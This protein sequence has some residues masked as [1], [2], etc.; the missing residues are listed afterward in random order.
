MR[1]RRF[2]AN[3]ASDCLHFAKFRPQ[4]SEFCGATYT[5]ICEMFSTL[6]STSCLVTDFENRVQIVPQT[7]TKLSKNAVINLALCCGAIWRH[8]EKPQHR[9]TT[10]IHP[11]YTTAQK[12]F[13]KFTFSMTFGA[14][15]LF[16]PSCFWTTNTKFWHLL[17]VLGS[18]ERQKFYIDAH[19]HTRP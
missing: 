15:N 13:W 11:L 6:Q 5:R 19:L 18:D 2:P 10:T 8:R 14:H 7:G 4:F 9:C 12:R 1:C 16:I 17:S 3:S